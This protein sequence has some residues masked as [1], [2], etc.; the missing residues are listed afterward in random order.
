MFN[1][2][3]GMG[4]RAHQARSQ[5][6]L[7]SDR[8]GGGAGRNSR[9][10]DADRLRPARSCAQAPAAAA[11]SHGGDGQ[12]IDFHM[13]TDQPWLLNA[14]PSRL[15]EGPEGLGGGEPGAAGHFLVNGKPIRQ[16]GKITI[17]PGDI[18]LL[19]TPGGGGYGS[20]KQPG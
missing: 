8:R 4:A 10:G 7:L 2:S 12:I 5:R 19:E 11:R 18:V 1:Y 14:V 16:A 6:H 17:K 15:D 3:G 9:S 20:P 13:R